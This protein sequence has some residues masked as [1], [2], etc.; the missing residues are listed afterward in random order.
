MRETF[1]FYF[2]NVIIY[3]KAIEYRG[4][5]AKHLGTS[6]KQASIT[7]GQK[8]FFFKKE[9]KYLSHITIL[10]EFKINHARTT[11]FQEEKIQNYISV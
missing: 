8:C 5:H 11:C 3:S 9:T 1:P 2:E 6:L 4:K 7:I 10:D